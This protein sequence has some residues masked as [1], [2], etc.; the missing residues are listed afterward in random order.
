MYMDQTYNVT[1]SYALSQLTILCSFIFLCTG[2][3]P[4]QYITIKDMLILLY[5]IL[6][7]EQIL[8]VDSLTGVDVV[9]LS[10]CIKCLSLS[11][12]AYQVNVLVII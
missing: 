5:A 10:M 11:Y 4:N 12:V 6:H 7:M 8:D 3:V 2:F 9:Q 1:T